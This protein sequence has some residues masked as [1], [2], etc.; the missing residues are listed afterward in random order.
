MLL[1]TLRMLRE[2][3]NTVVVVEHDEE[4]IRQAQHII[5]LGPG[6]GPLGGRLI[7]E[8]SIADIEKTSDSVTGRFLH[9][10]LKHRIDK[11]TR[12]LRDSKGDALSVTVRG[13]SLH[14][15]KKIRRCISP[16]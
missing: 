9:A 7:A 3:G 10:P 2:K 1:D 5:D 15:I 4:T 16:W 13:A 14:N 11:R 12:A 6:G 8:G